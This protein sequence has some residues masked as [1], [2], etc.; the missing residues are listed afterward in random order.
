M[1]SGEAHGN[2][3]IGKTHVQKNCTQVDW[4]TT[5]YVDTDPS[6][7]TPILVEVWDAVG[8][9]MAN[10]RKLGQ[11]E[12]E[13]VEVFTTPGRMQTQALLKGG[14]VEITVLESIQGDLMTRVNLQIRG[15]DIRNVE[16]GLLGLGRSDPFF[17]IAKKNAD[18]TTGIVRWVTVYRSEYIENHLNPFWNDLSLTTEELCFCNPETSIRIAVRDHENS[19]KHKKIGQ[20]E[21]S[22]SSMIESIAFKGNADREKALDLIAEDGR[23]TGLVILKTDLLYSAQRQD[24]QQTS[25][26]QQ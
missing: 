26:Y 7:K 16:P 13:V 10:H 12:F 1:T 5:L 17:E 9:D 11:A 18:P 3:E 4:T 6:I 25:L 20:V 8:D 14:Q 21:T 23:H 19:G 2:T 24:D 22:L 15:L